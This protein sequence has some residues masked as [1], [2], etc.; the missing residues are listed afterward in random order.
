MNQGILSVKQFEIQG[1][2]CHSLAH[3]YCH[4]G[5]KSQKSTI[6]ELPC[7]CNQQLFSVCSV[8]GV[9]GDMLALVQFHIS[10]LQAPLHKFLPPVI[11]SSQLEAEMGQTHGR[12]NPVSCSVQHQQQEQLHARLLHCILHLLFNQPCNILVLTGIRLIFRLLLDPDL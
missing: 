11:M 9:C 1:H 5:M 10:R 7:Q 4:L 8:T 3:D 12:S 6:R 2:T